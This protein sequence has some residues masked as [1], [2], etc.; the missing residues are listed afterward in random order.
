M[1][2]RQG[3]NLSPI[4]FSFFLNDLDKFLTDHNFNGPSDLQA[5]CRCAFLENLEIFLR[6]AIL[7]YADDMILLA[8][9]PEKLQQGLDLQKEYCENWK[10]TVNST[11]TKVVIFSRGRQRRSLPVFSYGDIRL[12]IVDE[13]LYL[14]VL[15]SYNGILQKAINRC[16]H[17][18]VLRTC[19]K[20]NLPIDLSLQLFDGSVTSNVLLL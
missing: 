14:G 9:S 3:E 7:L 2:V 6:L 10:L 12:D 16:Y 18:G 4:L 5:T 15:F 8:N 11:K 20:L 1:G 19:R 13:Y 17:K